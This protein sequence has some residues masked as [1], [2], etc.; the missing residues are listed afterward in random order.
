M[1]CLET[2]TVAEKQDNKAKL[3]NIHRTNK[4]IKVFPV[5]NCTRFPDQYTTQGKLGGTSFII[6]LVEGS[7]ARFPRAPAA[8]SKAASP[9]AFPTHSVKTGGS[10]TLSKQKVVVYY[11]FIIIIRNDSSHQKQILH[12]DAF[13]T[14]SYRHRIFGHNPGGEPEFLNGG[15]AKY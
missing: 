1:P 8:N 14:F 2:C 6:M 9:Q 15:N 13:V 5:Q 7:A 12:Q 4:A 10:I 3:T 11:L